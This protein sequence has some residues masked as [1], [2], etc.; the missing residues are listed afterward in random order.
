MRD[1]NKKA[2]TLSIMENDKRQVLA[3]LPLAGAS[4]LVLGVKRANFGSIVTDYVWTYTEE[5]DGKMVTTTRTSDVKI[6]KYD[7]SKDGEIAKVT[8]LGRKVLRRP[9]LVI[10]EHAI[11]SR[12]DSVKKYQNASAKYVSTLLFWDCLLFYFTADH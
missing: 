4:K 10:P 2:A 1:L 8:E 3:T 7:G 9:H 12:L 11:P 6:Q 5:I